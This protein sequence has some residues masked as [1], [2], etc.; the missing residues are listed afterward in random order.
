[1]L[2]LSRTFDIPICTT[3]DYHNRFPSD[4][5]DK[6][7]TTVR[8]FDFIQL[9]WRENTITIFLQLFSQWN[10]TRIQINNK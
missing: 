6:V 5:N 8:V 1:M 2:L 9:D 4:K 7:E 3:K 10:D